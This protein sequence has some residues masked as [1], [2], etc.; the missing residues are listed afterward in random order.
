M[1]RVESGKVVLA[2]VRDRGDTGLLGISLLTDPGRPVP[3][4]QITLYEYTVYYEAYRHSLAALQSPTS[5][6][7]APYLA[8]TELAVESSVLFKTSH[9]DLSPLHRPL[10]QNPPSACDAATVY[11]ALQ[12][13]RVSASQEISD[14]TDEAVWAAVQT[15]DPSQLRAIRTGALL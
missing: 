3:C 9:L 15:C 8:G 4:R 11:R 7:L 14:T 12:Q 10:P 6:P 2:A 13:P 5:V 1:L